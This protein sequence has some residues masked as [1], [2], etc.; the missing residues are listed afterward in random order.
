MTPD[1]IYVMDELYQTLFISSRDGKTVQ[2]LLATGYKRSADGRTWTISLRHGVRFSDGS[3][4]T[5]ADVK[6][7]LD[8]SRKANAAFSYLLGAISSIAAPSPFTV[9]IH[10]AA[11]SAPLLADLTA[12]V[13]EILPKNL[14]GKTNKVFFAHPVGTGPFVFDSWTRGKS[15]K[16]VRNTHYW[17]AG[18]PYLDSVTWNVV[19]DANTRVTQLLGGEADISQDVPLS[20]VKP[21]NS[22]PGLA[23]G[24]FPAAYNYFLIF[25]EAVKP[26][27]D[28]HVRRAIAYAIDRKTLV[29]AILFGVGQAACSIVPQSMVYWDSHTPCL[30][31]N[32]TKARAEL[33]RSTVP[34]GFKGQLLVDNLPTNL[35]GAQIVQS[36]LKQ[37]G[38]DLSLK[39]VD[40]GSLYTTYFGK[41]DYQAGFAAWAYDIPDPDEQISFMF[42]PKGGGNSYYTGYDNPTVTRLV[43]QAASTLNQA[44][45][46]V[47]QDPDDLGPG[48]APRAAL[49]GCLRGRLA[50]RRER[51]LRQPDGEAALRGRLAEQVVI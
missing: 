23:A 25:N 11:P 29:N 12:W 13:A 33:A 44:A 20:Q 14:E 50:A 51:L 7:S 24:S 8:R 5:S 4:L 42:D 41:G 27:Q 15:L 22:I 48:G 32:L 34:N 39:V 49:R 46:A 30:T 47:R 31:Y 9:V 19:P 37:I 38:I 26:Y 18:K 10:T 3:P 43:H 35:S 21:V 6:F 45:G 40:S 2:P 28:V 17:Q 16:A 36:D 1:E